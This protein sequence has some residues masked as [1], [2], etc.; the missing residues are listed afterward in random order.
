M[1]FLIVSFASMFTISIYKTSIF[2]PRLSVPGPLAY[3]ISSFTEFIPFCNKVFYFS[4]FKDFKTLA[5]A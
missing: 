3:I 1:L 4:S 2:Q 5:Q